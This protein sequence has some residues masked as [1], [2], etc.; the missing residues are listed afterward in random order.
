MAHFHLIGIGGTGLS[1][2]ARVLYESGEKVTGSDAVM[3]PLA[4][5]LVDL[6]IPVI[7]G[8]R[9]ENIYGAETIIRSSAI[10]D[11]NPEVKAA[12]AA[13]IPVLKRQ[14]FLQTLT[15]DKKVIAIAGTHGKTTTT[16][17]IAWCLSES[18]FSP[19]YVIGGTS[20]NL[21]KNASSGAG[22]LFVI[23]ADEYDNM[24]LGLSPDI[25]LITNIEHDHPDCFPT[26][27]DYQKAF[28]KL[29]KQVRS[30]GAII[31]C[32]DNEG[33]QHLLPKLKTDAAVIR[34]GRRIENDILISEI[35]DLNGGTSF[36]IQDRRA[37]AGVQEPIHLTLLLPG[38]HNAY[39]ACA[40]FSAAFAAGAQAESLQKALS[41]F[42]GTGR[43][44]DVLGEV[45]GITL[46]DDYAH[47]PTE[48]RATLSAARSR[49]PNGNVW[50]VWQPHTYSR[51]QE[52]FND[53]LASFD[54]CDH[55][56]VTEIYRSREHEQ[57][58]SSEL[59]VQA[60]VHADK[61]YV[62]TLDEATY[63]LQNQLTA[64]DIL[65]VLSAGDANRI[66]QSVWKA[67]Q[68]KEGKK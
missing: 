59:L 34:Y 61:K 2:I 33:I 11:T 44:F 48:I 17:M 19:S 4:E 51:T 63:I 8:H 56:I 24:F 49:Y 68:E 66:T 28:L 23:E 55:L 46:I 29:T 41:E 20:K 39:N 27:A 62:Q 38:M 45:N 32:S 15:K 31:V 26:K 53:F 54:D 16:A 7:I 12:I 64:G 40:A 58:Y 14:D 21:G 3:S 13:G 65:I 60:L 1:A 9:A 37:A 36:T 43:R 25:L 57:D 10:P 5:E 67:L 42:S 18:G 50:V 52:L 47:H 22:D 30:K 35:N 6:G